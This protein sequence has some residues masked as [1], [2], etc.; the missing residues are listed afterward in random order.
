M[1]WFYIG[2][3]P[4]EDMTFRVVHEYEQV[5]ENHL[6]AK[7][8][9]AVRL[10]MLTLDMETK[11]RDEARRRVNYLNGGTGGPPAAIN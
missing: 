8:A 2:V 5:H 6:E 11:D 4:E 9:G 1:S 7:L 3:G 10:P